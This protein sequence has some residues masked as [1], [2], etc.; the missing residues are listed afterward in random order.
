VRAILLAAGKGT[1]ISKDIGK[2]CK[3]LLDIGG[4]SLIKHTVE[5]LIKHQVEVHIVLGYQRDLITKELEGYNVKFYYN[6][7]YS[8]TNSIAS[9]WFAKESLVEDEI[10]LG[11]ADVYWDNDIFSSLANDTRKNT[12]LADS[13]RIDAY[14]GD[15]F[16]MHENDLLLGHGKGMEQGK[17]TAEYVG[18]AKIQGSFVQ[19]FRKRL[20]E[21]I[22][23][24]QPQMWW[25][26]VMFSYI[27]MHDIYVKDI[28]GMF[29]MEIDYIDDYYKIV[30]YRKENQL[31]TP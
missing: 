28:K 27:G 7:F 13:S 2:T 23:D 1:R 15:Y 31:F 26:D 12:M 4:T 19:A 5:M 10:I 20:E 24:Q 22:D 17:I 21:L 30:E 29:W 11:N 14:K 18:L 16:F 6:P 3:C 25:E 8:V 9:L